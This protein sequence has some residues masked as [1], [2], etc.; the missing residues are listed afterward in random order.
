[1]W[2]DAV[3]PRV[4]MRPERGRVS[5]YRFFIVGLDGRIFHGVE[6]ECFDD[7]DALARARDRREPRAIEVWQGKRLVGRV[8]AHDELP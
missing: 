7:A 1:M 2:T 8:P 6:A 3:A 4:Q 5:D